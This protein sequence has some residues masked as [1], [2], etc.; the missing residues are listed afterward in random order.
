MTK[1]EL[2]NILQKDN[3]SLDTPIIIYLECTNNDI[4]IYGRIEELTYDKKH[5]E[6]HIV[7]TY[8]EDEY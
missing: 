2:I 1:G 4:E 6:L 5:K 7:G 3:S 8:E